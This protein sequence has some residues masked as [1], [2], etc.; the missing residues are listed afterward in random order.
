MRWED[1]RYVRVYTRD[2]T[3]WIALSWQARA[4]FHELLRK[5]DRAGLMPVGK[6]GTKGLAG[7]L[8]MPHDVVEA[9]LAELLE[10]TCLVA[11]DDGYLVRNFLEAQE[12]RASDKARKASQRER[13]RDQAGRTGTRRDQPPSAD[14][15]E[16]QPVTNRDDE[17]REARTRDQVS[18]PGH[19]GSQP[20]TPSLAVPSRA[21]PAAAAD[22]R[23]DLP[24]ETAA[25]LAEL[26]R[27]PS[28]ESVATPRFADALA[29]RLMTNGKQLAWCL[30]GIAEAA[31]D[32]SVAGLGAE[33]LTRKVRGYFDN[34]RAPRTDQVGPGP[35]PV[36]PRNAFEI[37]RDPG[38]M[39][40][41]ERKQRAFQA[42][43]EEAERRGDVSRI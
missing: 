14:P 24:P 43:A 17:S 23:D 10:D 41:I 26:R 15:S 35:T 38:E 28:L 19:D 29:G 39:A 3:E 20:V 6:A 9:A 11:V 33:A 36:R 25:I 8:R 42:E 34:A 12:A 21:E 27:H 16:G 40:E 2:T 37:Q 31:V 32:A 22:A 4:L 30:G 18:R 13:A 5:V 1:E 7:L